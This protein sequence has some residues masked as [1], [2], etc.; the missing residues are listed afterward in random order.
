LRRPGSGR[1][2]G[3]ANAGQQGDDSRGLCRRK[4]FSQALEMAARKVSRLVREHAYD[5]VRGLGVKQRAGI[6]ED[7]P[8]VHDERVKRTVAQ[9]HH[10]HILLG[11]SCCA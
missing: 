10:P 2:D 6:D 4:L 7:M 3:S 5:F 11:K 1:S 9:D 8:P